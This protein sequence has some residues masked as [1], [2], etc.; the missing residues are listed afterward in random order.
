MTGPDHYR[1]A[2]EQIA[3]AAR[4][5]SPDAEQYHL[6]RAQ[7]HA[8][9][10]LAAATDRAESGDWSVESELGQYGRPTW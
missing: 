3:L 5:D 8:T 7:A 10:A 2:E 4:A 1:E 9:L 6:G